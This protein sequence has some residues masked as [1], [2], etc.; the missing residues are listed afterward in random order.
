MRCTEIHL[1]IWK[2]LIFDR[3]LEFSFN[4]S[5]KV[6]CGKPSLEWNFPNFLFTFSGN[7]E[8]NTGIM[9]SASYLTTPHWQKTSSVLRLNCTPEVLFGL[10]HESCRDGSFRWTEFEEEKRKKASSLSQVVGRRPWDWLWLRVYPSSFTMEMTSTA[11]RTRARWGLGEPWRTR[12]GSPGCPPSPA[13]SAGR[14]AVSSPA[15]P[16]GSVTGGVC[17]GMDL[18]IT[19]WSREM[20]SPGESRVVFVYLR[21]SK[22]MIQDRLRR[23]ENHYF[24]ADMIQTQFAALEVGF[25]CRELFLLSFFR[26]RL[27]RRET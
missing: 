2:G 12:T 17:T 10:N 25:L 16:W 14:R 9:T 15:P 20:L 6:N 26:N 5:L 21:G 19:K 27:R 13:S 22:Q 23:R 11:R 1:E 7:V 8:F 3:Y 18:Q 24:K 4:I